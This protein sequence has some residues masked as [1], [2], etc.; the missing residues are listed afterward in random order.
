[1]YQKA[2]VCMILHFNLQTYYFNAPHFTN[3]EQPS[4]VYGISS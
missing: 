2:A 1:M 4:N 3:A